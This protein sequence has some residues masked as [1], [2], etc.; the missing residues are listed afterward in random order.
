MPQ[1]DVLCI[2]IRALT[3]FFMAALVLSGL[4]AL[5]LSYELDYLNRLVGPQSIFAPL[6]PNVTA[7]IG[8]VH[9]GLLDSWSRYPFLAYGTDWLAF[10]HFVIALAFLGVQHDPIKNRWVVEWSMLACVLVIPWTLVAGAVRGIPWF[11]QCVDM[12][13]GI[14]GIIPLLFLRRDI[15]RL[16]SLP[17]P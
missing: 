3:F 6:F 11:W 1:R 7:W 13:F 17:L 10:A 2:R 4:T 15:R 5:P 8:R 12:S 14:V 16:E 9:D